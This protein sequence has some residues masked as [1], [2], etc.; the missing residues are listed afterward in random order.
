MRPESKRPM[1]RFASLVAGAAA[2]LASLGCTY[3]PEGRRAVTG[4]DIEGASAVDSGDLE[5]KLATKTTSRFFGFRGIVYEYEIY[6]RY[7]LEQDLARIERY[8]RAR[9]YYDARVRVA[10]VHDIGD[11]KVSVEIQVDEGEPVRVAKFD[12]AWTHPVSDAIRAAV[13]A[14]ARRALGREGRPF[15]ETRFEDAE[16]AIT[17]ALADRGYAAAATTREAEV[18]VVHRQ[19]SLQFEVTPGEPSVFGAVTF[20]GRGEIPEDPVRRAFAIKPGDDYSLAALEDGR[21]ALLDLSVFSTVDIVPDLASEQREPSGQH[22]KVVPV[23]VHLEV[24]KLRTLRLGGGLEISSSRLDLHGLIGWRN[25]NTFGHLRRVELTFRP[26]VVLWPTNLGN[27]VAPQKFLPFQRTTATLRR[28]AFIESRTTGV[29]TG[30]YAIFPQLLP[31]TTTKNVIGYHSIAST[32]GLERS[33]G[34][35]FGRPGYGF[36][37]NFPYN[38]VGIAPEHLQPVL[39]SYVE[40]FSYLDFRNDPLKPTR[41]A[42]FGNTFQFAGGPFSGTADDL[43]IQPE[44]RGYIPL[45]RHVSIALRAAVGFLFPRN[46]GSAASRHFESPERAAEVQRTDLSRDYQIL[47]FRGLFSGGS[48]SNRGYPLRGIGPHDTIPYLVPQVTQAQGEADCR[49]ENPNP[50]RACLLPTGGVSQWESSLELRFKISG[51]LLAAAFCDAGDVSARQVNLRF[52]RLHL[53]CG[54]GIRYDTPAGPIRFD[55]GVRI[56]GLQTLGSSYGEGEPPTL[57]GAPIALAFGI[58]E[59]F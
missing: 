46:Y 45:G 43:R 25:E 56:P 3:V 37:A 10:R 34:R 18:D 23:K 41:G 11:D 5:E 30:E 58:G 49:P 40:F 53:S 8:Y 35:F 39:V 29:V 26:G 47:Y 7:T 19:A 4:F 32:A 13:Q 36:Q 21:Q 55:L 12:I 28:P 31:G 16:K 54:P 6:D 33:F 51:P 27:F 15:D 52:E 42:Y 20:E 2:A 17:R 22:R 48:N 24:S 50:P 57:L 1:L 59:A 9:G 44:A 38:A 14:S